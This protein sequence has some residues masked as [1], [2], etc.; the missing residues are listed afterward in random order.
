MG[1]VALVVYVNLVPYACRIWRGPDWVAQYLPDEGHLV[2]GLLFFVIVALFYYIS[3]ELPLP[4]GQAEI[5]IIVALI[6]GVF[7]ILALMAKPMAVSLPLVLIL[8]DLYPYRRLH[9]SPAQPGAHD[10]QRVLARLALEKIPFIL[11]VL[12]V[13]AL[14]VVAQ[15]QGGSIQALDVYPLAQRILNSFSSLFSCFL[16]SM[17]SSSNVNMPCL[18][19][20]TGF[21]HFPLS[22]KYF[23]V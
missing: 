17:V 13:I 3:L 8:L 20:A 7:A 21:V 11:A 14:T 15:R 9:W 2:L 19:L 23:Y 18:L 5:P 4:I 12:G 6:V 22:K 1:S 10:R 16:L